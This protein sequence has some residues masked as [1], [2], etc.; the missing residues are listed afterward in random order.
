MAHRTLDL[1]INLILVG[2]CLC[3]AAILVVRWSEAK[4]TIR[5]DSLVHAGLEVGRKADNLSGVSYG[6]A[7]FTFL[8]FFRTSCQYCRENAGF[9]RQLGEKTEGT[10]IRF[11]TASLEEPGVVQAFF[12]D[13]D[14]RTDGIV[15]ATVRRPTPILL[16]VDG[17]GV[18]RHIWIGQQNAE[19]QRQ[20]LS[21][22]DNLTRTLNQAFAEPRTLRMDNILDGV[23]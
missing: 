13:H 12:K 16:L 22:L 2:V 8:L 1:V 3:L 23:R 21:V 17:P 14:I 19:S 20:I 15:A 11:I 6:A 18:I 5:S 9:Y 4:A 7:P 10:A